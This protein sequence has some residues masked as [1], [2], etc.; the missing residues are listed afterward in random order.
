MSQTDAKKY[1]P[2]S[3]KKLEARLLPGQFF[4]SVCAL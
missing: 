3:T 2:V 1:L 4:T